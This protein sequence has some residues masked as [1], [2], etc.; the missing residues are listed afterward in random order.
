MEN[1]IFFSQ[2]P[3]SPALHFA[4]NSPAAV[5]IFI[6][7]YLYINMFICLTP[8]SAHFFDFPIER[9]KPSSPSFKST[10]EN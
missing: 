8:T 5:L 3:L 10:K 4:A 1:M 6:Y 9:I 2:N 7:Y